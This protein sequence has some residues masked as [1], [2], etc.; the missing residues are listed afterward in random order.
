M[1]QNELHRSLSRATG[2]SVRTI[3]RLGFSP[4]DPGANDTDTDSI[5]LPPQVVDWDRLE[6]DRIALAIQA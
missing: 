5:D 3:K 6:L 2:E 4:F 1:S